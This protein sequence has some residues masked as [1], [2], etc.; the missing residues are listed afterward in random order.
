MRN[1]KSKTNKN[2]KKNKFI[3]L[4]KYH[5]LGVCLEVV[6]VLIVIIFQISYAIVTQR[7]FSNFKETEVSTGE[8]EITFETSQYINAN[9]LVPISSSSVSTESQLII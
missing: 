4:N 3:N 7:T 2:N 5:F 9:S 1:I 6:L 8:L